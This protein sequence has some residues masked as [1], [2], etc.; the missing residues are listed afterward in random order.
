MQ[1]L[2]KEYDIAYLCPNMINFD[3]LDFSACRSEEVILLLMLSVIN[4]KFDVNCL[5][6]SETEVFIE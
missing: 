1:M 3:A 6:S 4:L 2:I 5:K